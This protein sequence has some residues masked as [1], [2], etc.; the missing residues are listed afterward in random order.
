M[1]APTQH[2]SV[3]AYGGSALVRRLAIHPQQGPK[4]L[5]MYRPRERERG[6]TGTK[7]KPGTKTR[8]AP[9]S[10]R[11]VAAAGH[12]TAGDKK[13]PEPMAS[14]QCDDQCHRR[15]R[16]R[17]MT[18]GSPFHTPF[19]NKKK[20]IYQNKQRSCRWSEGFSALKGWQH[21]N[22]ADGAIIG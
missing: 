17:L 20:N 19:S 4:N 1:V 21:N 18:N 10:H 2:R 22:P 11:R 14:D 15:S 16:S 7:K 13:G 12:D 9:A 8:A 3:A 5:F 6:G